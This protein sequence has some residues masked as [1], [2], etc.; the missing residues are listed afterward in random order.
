MWILVNIFRNR[1]IKHKDSFVA[2]KMI[3]GDTSSE[4]SREDLKD[5]FDGLEQ[6]QKDHYKG[7]FYSVGY[8]QYPAFEND[9]RKPGNT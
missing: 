1:N 3:F 5:R 6:G 8:L 9:R 2:L 7:I 4:V